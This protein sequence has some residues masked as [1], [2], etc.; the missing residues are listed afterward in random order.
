MAPCFA[1]FIGCQGSNEG[2]QTTQDDGGENAN[3]GAGDSGTGNDSGSSDDSG[4]SGDSGQSDDCDGE[5]FAVNLPA[6]DS[7]HEEDVEWWYWTGHLQDE[8]GSWYGFEHV[9]FRFLMGDSS[10]L[11][12]HHAI[13][14]VENNTFD[15]VAS[16]GS[17]TTQMVIDGFAFAQSGQ[18]A[19][20]GDGAD[21]IHG[22]L[23]TSTLDLI[24]NDTKKPVLQH[25]TG[26]TDYE[27]GGY[28]YYYSRTRMDAAGTLQINGETKNVTGTGW[29]DHQWGALTQVTNVG[30]DWF[31]IQLDDNREIMLFVV[32][33]DDKSALVGG[34]MVAADGTSTE[35]DGSDYAITAHNEWTS[36]ESG[37]VYPI[38]WTVQ[39]GDMTLEIQ[40]VMEAQEVP[41][42][43]NTYWEGAA[44]VSGDA[45]GRAYIE[46]TGYCD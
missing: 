24:L 37:C 5:P 39:V 20:G 33:P 27:F 40:S 41:N 17:D 38:D 31:A 26:Y 11:M 1:L 16:Y 29:F 2:T 23:D 8:E 7:M 36:P 22:E 12:A 30:W 3:N 6:D 34:T 45:T 21:I 42:A 18:T 32:R 19:E 35:I 10:F 14:D 13:T 28:T 15:Y 43:A 4:T 46:L 25:C 44:T 9:F